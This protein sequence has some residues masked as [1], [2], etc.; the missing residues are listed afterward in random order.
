MPKFFSNPHPKLQN[1]FPQKILTL[2]HHL[3]PVLLFLGADLMVEYTYQEAL[4][5]LQKNLK[6]AKTNINTYTEDLEYL[7]E[8]ITTIEVNLARVHNYKVKSQGGKRV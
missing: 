2:T 7:R 5:L 6:N 8:Q 1:K 3:T 4:T